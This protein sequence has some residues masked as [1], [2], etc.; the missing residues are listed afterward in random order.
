MTNNFFVKLLVII[1]FLLLLAIK[2]SFSQNFFNQ[3]QVHGNFQ[4]DAMYYQ[5]DS[6]IGTKNVPEKALMNGFGNVIYTNGNFSAGFRYEAYLNPLQGYDSDYKGTGIP[7]RYASF[8]KDNFDITIGN[9][10]EQFGAGLVYRTYEDKSLGYDNA[11]DGIK[12][13]YSPING[14]T[15]K[16]IWGYQRRYWTKGPGIVRGADID[17]AIMDAFKKLN[18]IKTKIIVGGSFVSKYQESLDNT[19]KMPAN[20]ACYGGRLNIINGG[21]NFYAEYAQK[22]NDPE[23]NNNKIY[24]QGEALLIQTSYS[25]SGIGVFLS[26]KRL[27]NMDFR[28]DY[29]AKGNLLNINYLPAITKQHTYTLAAYYPYGTQPNGE[30]GIDGQVNFSF[31]KGSKLGGKYGLNIALDFSRINS[32]Y[33]EKIESNIPIDSTGTLGYKSPFFKIGNEEYFQDFSIE[34]TKKLSKKFK[35]IFAY[36]NINYNSKV[37]E[38]HD[39]GMIYTN[40]PVIDLTYFITPTKSLR[41]ELQYLATQQ[42]DHDW[43]NGLLEFTIAPKWYFTI[44]D[45]Y[46][47]NNPLPEKR[48]HYYYGAIAFTKGSSRIALSY[49][50]QRAGIVCVGGVCRAVP[51]SNGITLSITSSF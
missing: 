39:K 43:I 14:L 31:K 20:V 40:I 45:S 25:K 49:G 16:G 48:L 15:F 1:S 18:D 7:Y 34:I 33:K 37:I 30:M 35:L 5:Q 36:Y 6:L 12:I 44:M 51:A 46:N 17:F 50:R 38:G 2:P 29:N 41:A 23:A 11:M 4:M 28:S 21:F 22:I 27:D 9:F 42:D 32:I 3:S 13:R 26:A 19:Y 10:Y 24:K 8:T 47:Y